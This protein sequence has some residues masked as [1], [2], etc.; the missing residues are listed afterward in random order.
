MGGSTPEAL[1]LQFSDATF[2]SAAASFHL[3]SFTEGAANGYDG[4]KGMPYH[5]EPIRHGTCV[6]QAGAGQ[7]TG[8]E[9]IAAALALRSALKHSERITHAYVDLTNVDGTTITL[10]DVRGLAAIHSGCAS[11]FQNLAIAIAAPSDLI[12]GV[13]RMYGRSWV[14]PDGGFG[15]PERKRKHGLG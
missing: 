2:L 14:R 9:V 3:K 6:Y 4:R 8:T 15:W 7:L 10:E 11:I 1:P 12:F 13:S 5:T